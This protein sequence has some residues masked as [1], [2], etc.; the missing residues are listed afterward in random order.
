MEQA[1]DNREQRVRLQGLV[2]AP[3]GP[4]LPDGLVT[5]WVLS[6]HW[7]TELN[8]FAVHSIG[9]FGLRQVMAMGL[10]LRLGIVGIL[11]WIAAAAPDVRA[12]VGARWMLTA[13]ALWW[14]LIAVGNVVVL[15]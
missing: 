3:L 9:S 11:T 15:A 7:S 1:Q 2:L 8:P 10:A 12:R 13:T 6:H 5:Y 4:S 14:T